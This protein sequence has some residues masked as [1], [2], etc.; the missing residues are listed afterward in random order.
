MQRPSWK[1]ARSRFRPAICEE[2]S[3]GNSMPTSRELAS[4]SPLP[5]GVHRVPDCTF[6]R[7]WRDDWQACSRSR[8]LF[9]A[10][11]AFASRLRR[12]RKIRKSGVAGGHNGAGLERG[13]LRARTLPTWNWRGVFIRGNKQPSRNRPWFRPTRSLE[14]FERRVYRRRSGLRLHRSIRAIS[15]RVR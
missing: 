11:T 5:F 12:M 9:R 15:T 4:R 6:V 7:C 2:I 3:P 10:G 13:D 1:A 14:R 8:V